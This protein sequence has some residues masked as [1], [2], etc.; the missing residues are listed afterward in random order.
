MK[1]ITYAILSLFIIFL[2]GCKEDEDYPVE[3]F[4]PRIFDTQNAFTSPNRII[5]EG[6]PAVYSGLKF[7]PTTNGKTKVSWKVNGVEV[8]TD[9]TFTF[10]PEGGGEFEI[11]VEATYN[12]LTSTRISKVLVSPLTFTPKNSPFVTMAYLSGAATAAN[13][14]WSN[15][16]HVAYNGA[17]VV[18]G[19]VVDFTNANTNQNIDEIIARGH[20]NGVPVLLGISGQLSG[21]DGGALYGSSD[22]G[23]VISDP[24][25]RTS[26][27]TLVSA[28]VT[29][30]R[31]D[32][33]DLLM[34][35]YN[36]DV[37]ARNLQALTPFIAELKA[38]LPAGALVTVTVGVGWQHWDYTSLLAADWLNVRAF[39]NGEIGPGSVRQQQS[40][41]SFMQNGANIWLNKGYP[42]N[43]LVIGM[44][45]FGIR[46]NELDVNDNNLGWGSYA[47]MPYKDIVA[48]DPTAPQKESTN[49]I[50]QGVYY[51]GIP[52][53]TQKANYIKTHGFKGAYLWAGD[54]DATGPNSLMAV[55]NTILN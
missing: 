20:I 2:G 1:K 55:I 12:G 28:Y 11:T 43:K 49:L 24:A 46:Y 16:T 38:A 10:V 31:L 52:L 42:A 7:S 4:Q 29:N 44:P 13:V 8:S 27:V 36:N 5:L 35:D 23:N 17:R 6:Q 54:Y 18:A 26:L 22:F 47:Y 41:L 45:A 40:P 30:R 53:I 25:S 50:A 34:T 48:A 33:V 32:G 39:E 9:T 21:I 37:Y 19:E 14:D 3:N 51:N 15:V